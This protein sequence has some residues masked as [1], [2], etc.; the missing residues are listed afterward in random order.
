MKTPLLLLSAL[1]C[2]AG[3]FKCS[4]CHQCTRP[5]DN[6]KPSPVL[7]PPTFEQPWWKPKPFVFPPMPWQT[8]VIFTNAISSNNWVTLQ[9][10]TD[11]TTNVWKTNFLRSSVSITNGAEYNSDHRA[12]SPILSEAEYASLLQIIWEFRHPI[13]MRSFS[14]RLPAFQFDEFRYMEFPETNDDG[15]ISG[16][17]IE[18]KK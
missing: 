4:D 2:Q 16:N 13:R 11:P 8:N 1:T 18:R 5:P 9:L 17:L 14:V 10:P 15:T 12:V 3:P 6:S 7:S